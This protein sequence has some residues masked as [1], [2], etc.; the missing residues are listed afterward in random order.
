AAE[1]CQIVEDV[2]TDLNLKDKPRVTALNKID[3]LLDNGKT[4]DEESAINYLSDQHDVI[5]KNT[6]LISA[7]KGWGLTK[8]LKLISGTLAKTAQPV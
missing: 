2:L 1:Q 6:V 8:L 3:L 5:N 7:T 4:W